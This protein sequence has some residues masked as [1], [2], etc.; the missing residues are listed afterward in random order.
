MTVKA[1]VGRSPQTYVDFATADLLEQNSKRT[2]VN[3]I[4]NAK[5]ALHFQVDLL[6]DALGFNQSP[7]RKRNN[8]PEKLNFCG[9]CGIVAPRILEKINRQRNALEHD[10]YIPT[11]PQS[12]DFL[13]VVMLFLGATNRLLAF[14][15]CNVELTSIDDF[16]DKR[17]QI[18]L[19]ADLTPGAGVLKL[20][21]N[22]MSIGL[23]KYLEL[24]HI[25][26]TKSLHPNLDAVYSAVRMAHS[27]RSSLV[28]T[29]PQG[30]VYCKWL[31]VIR[32]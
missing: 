11:R 6:S 2:R 20:T 32:L 25:E 17:P 9:K 10:Y 27:K 29:A 19:S 26:K 5:R 28:V 3:A 21:L 18:F 8:F 15:P 30:E 4:S 7:L 14:F 24:A 16:P 12:E 23:K 13:D 22:Q 1:P 31:S